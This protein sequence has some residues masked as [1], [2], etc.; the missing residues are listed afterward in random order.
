MQSNFLLEIFTEEIP[1]S[2]QIQAHKDIQSLI[3]QLLLDNN[4]GYGKLEVFSTPLRL[5]VL[6][7][8]ISN[9][10]PQKIIEKKGPR[11]DA[12]Q[13]NMEAFLKSNNITL[14]DCIIKKTDKFDFYIYEQ[15]IP[16]MD[17]D[18]FLEMQ[19][20]SH[21]L[22]ALS[23]KKSMKWDETNITWARPIRNIFAII[24]SNANTKQLSFNYGGIKTSNNIVGHKFKFEEKQINGIEEYFNYLK[25]STIELNSVIRKQNIVDK[26][27][28]IA[29]E[30]G[31]EIHKDDKLFDELSYLVETP[32]LYVGTI[33]QKYMILPAELLIN[34]IVKNQRYILLIDKNQQVFNKFIII[35]NIDAKDDGMN[36]IKGNE[37]VL[38]ARL[39]DALFFYNQDLKTKLIDK[40]NNLKNINYFEGLGSIWDKKERVKLLF[41]KL[42]N[43]KQDLLCDLYKADLTSQ[44]VFEFPELQGI[45]GYYYAKAE[46]INNEYALAIKESYKPQ[47]VNDD[48]PISILGAKLA[49]LDK[50]DSLISFFEIG[51]KPT[52]SKDPYSLRRSAIG[53]IRII[54]HHDFSIN[55]AQFIKQDLQ[56]FLAER[57]IFY[58]EGQKQYDVNLVKSLLLQD[59]HLNIH[60]L[61][62]Q[63]KLFD[64]FLKLPTTLDFINLYK[65]IHN[66]INSQKIDL[67]DFNLNNLQDE[68]DVDLNKTI[69]QT[70]NGVNNLIKLNKH[71]ES[72]LQLN[73]L[74]PLVNNFLDK[75]SIANSSSLEVKKARLGMLNQITQTANLILPFNLII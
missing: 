41:S 51:K 34:T 29:K 28:Q 61:F 64:S 52:G 27:L 33:P 55:L 42:F 75:V 37:K 17:I 40:A 25:I 15:K 16:Q 67:T 22:P 20:P 14:Q 74:Q 39:E 10:V 72:I 63:V 12:P 11:I 30:Y 5:V 70:L 48:V 56:E 38:K 65:R 24:Q 53:I 46:G 8:E 49:L 36:V 26:A 66:I 57:I 2:L 9:F 21:I 19:I 45:M 35:S 4:I 73:S 44:S 6:I 18:T 7:N 31:C 62:N 54:L 69:E 43:E 68:L 13:N 60:L 23:F 1:Y 58:F 50:L 32:V 59:K 47:G 3:T 71:E